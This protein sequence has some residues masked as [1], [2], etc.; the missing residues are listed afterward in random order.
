MNRD[1]ALKLLRGGPDGIKEWN[2]RRDTGHKPN[3][4]Y[5]NLHMANL[6]K[7]NLGGCNLSLTDLSY[8]NLSGASLRYTH[9][10][11]TN[12]NEATLNGTRLD[13]ALFSRTI[14]SADLSLAKGLELVKHLGPSVV[15]M[16]SILSFKGN[17]PEKFLRGCGVP[18]VLIEYLP[19]LRSSIQPIEYYSCFISYSHKDKEFATR[20]HA[21]MQQ[22]GL[23]VWFAPEDLKAGKKI[24]EQIDEGIRVYD[25]LLLVI[26]PESMKSDW[27]ELEIR[28]ARDRERKE[29]RKMFF[30]ISITAFS[31][32]KEWKL[33]DADEGRDLAAEIREYQIPDFQN[34]KQHDAFEKTFA[35]LLRDL[36]TD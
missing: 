16:N 29:S 23:R 34:W 9:L 17:L 22:E 1:E 31:D 8:A 6:C 24:H 33:P 12:L 2:K 11:A 25:K 32:I 14:I 27:V 21:R 20:L 4:A 7:A 10:A 30:P 35:R 36:K 26:S 28:K 5:A 19:S 15:S 13:H 3:L 18:E